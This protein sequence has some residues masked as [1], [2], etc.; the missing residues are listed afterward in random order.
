MLKCFSD[1]KGE[2]RSAARAEVGPVQ[3]EARRNG[4]KTGRT[5]PKGRRG[6]TRQRYVHARKTHG[7][8]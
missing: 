3:A 8:T 2:V 4:P 1:S 5:S 6:G 7:P